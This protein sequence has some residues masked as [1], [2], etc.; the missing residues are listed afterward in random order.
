METF[1][2]WELNMSIFK[3]G[4]FFPVFNGK[5]KSNRLISHSNGNRQ[6]HIN[7]HIYILTNKGQSTDTL[8]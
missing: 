7:L 6:T 8:C 4:Y 5:T 2:L 3:R 1:K